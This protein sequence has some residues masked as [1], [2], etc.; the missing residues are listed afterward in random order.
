[1]K[2]KEI[3][4]LYEGLHEISQDKELKFGVRIS[5]T[6]AKDKNILQPYYDAI[7]DT[8]QKILEKYGE[9]QDNG[10]WHINKEKMDVFMS[11][12]KAFMEIEN[13]IGLDGVKIEDLDGEKIG[14]ELIEKIL[15][16][17]EQ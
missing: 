3:F 6:L 10:D 7:I 12:W 15:P 9:P 5:Y 4:N 17:I 11:E 16:I 8:R 13:Y 1:M 2:N 14:I